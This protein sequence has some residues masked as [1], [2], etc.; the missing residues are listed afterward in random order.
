VTEL[1]VRAVSKS[2][3]GIQALRD[4]SFDVRDGEILGIMGAN[5]AGKTT[6]FSLIAGHDRP[7]AGTIVFGGRRING[8]S[9][10]RIC[11]L[12]IARTFQ[13]VR[14]FPGMTVLDNVLVAALFG[15][16]Q[17]RDRARAT[18]RA[19]E[20]LAEVGL[21]DRAGDLASS[22]TLSRQKRLEIGRALAT[23]PKLIMLDEVMAG[24]NA[25]EVDEVLDAIRRIKSRRALTV[26][27]VEHV[28]QAVMRLSDRVVVLH[29]GE[30]IAIG[31]PQ[32]V[33]EDERVIEAY[34]GRAS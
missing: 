30:L 5:G 21:L 4:I 9:P 25:A 1:S 10:D 34:L 16:R 12:G 6:L 29:H 33:A 22:L 20:I 15:S 26:L 7:S 23:D 32:A 2:F 14:P 8:L 27:M 3:G 31:A 11:R 18:R 28:M 24:L 19:R 17:E 13:V